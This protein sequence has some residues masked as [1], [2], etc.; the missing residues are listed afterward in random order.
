[1]S[2]FISRGDNSG[3][4]KMELSIW[5]AAGIK[6]SGD[7]YIQAGQG[8]GAVLMMAN[9]KEAY[10]L[11]D[12]GTYYAMIDKLNLPIAFS[13]DSLL[14]NIYSVLRLNPEKH[15]E[16]KHAEVQKFIAWITSGETRKLIGS[17]EV[18][19]HLLFKVQE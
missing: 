16:L 2:E 12:T 5:E 4:H 8:M 15:P 17:F 9:E 19:G 3:T 13:G 10:T 18:N 14:D 1:K 7:W 11:T 6:P